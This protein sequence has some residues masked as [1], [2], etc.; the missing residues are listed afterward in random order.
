[1]N[2]IE[3]ATVEMITRHGLNCVYKSLTDPVYNVETG[4]ATSAEATYNVRIYK[5]HLGTNQY[6]YP[7]LIGKDAGMFYF[8]AVGLGFIPKNQD[9]F[10]YA[11]KTYKIEEVRTHVAYGSV[12]LYKVVACA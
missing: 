9:H 3:R 4:T 8:A 11:G 1:M 12:I 5:K 7:N 10:S 2:Q 6:N